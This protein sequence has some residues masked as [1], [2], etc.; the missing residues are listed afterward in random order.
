MRFSVLVALS[1]G[2][3]V[4]V[5]CGHFECLDSQP[6]I[7]AVL[8]RCLGVLI[9]L[10]YVRTIVDVTLKVG[11]LAFKLWCP[12]CKPLGLMSCT[13]CLFSS[14]YGLLRSPR[15]NIGT[16]RRRSSGMMFVSTCVLIT[17]Q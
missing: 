11:A 10:A 17:V 4:G 7:S 8:V 13:T 5:K 6:H 15:S 12:W 3:A 1:E 2:S 9:G 14:G 16:L